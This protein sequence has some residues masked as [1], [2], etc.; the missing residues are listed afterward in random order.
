LSRDQKF[1]DMYSLVIGVLVVVALPGSE[2]GAERAAVKNADPSSK[3]SVVPVFSST[4]VSDWFWTGTLKATKSPTMTVLGVGGPVATTLG[5]WANSTCAKPLAVPVPGGEDITTVAVPT[6]VL[7]RKSKKMVPSACTLLCTP[8][9]PLASAVALPILGKL[10][11]LYGHRRVF[12]LGSSAATLLSFLTAAAWDAYSLI[13]LRVAASVIGAASGPSSMALIFDAYTPEERT[14]A[15]G[16]WSM[17]GAGA[18]ALG[19]IAGGPMVQYMGWRMLFIVQGVFSVLALVFA[20]FVLVET[21]R[22]KVR[23]DVAG[24]FLLAVS[25]GCLMFALGQAGELGLRSPWIWGAIV[26]GEASGR[27]DAAR[28]L[29]A[30]ALVVVGVALL[31][32]GG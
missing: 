8:G 12:L 16:W 24:S 5:I 30:S 6:S 4:R 32:L 2:V 27:R 19:L 3:A 1:F 28:R 9:N 10:G 18:P 22:L 31:V 14:R 29:V 26:L 17:M 23:F 7:E 20:W 25:A 11:D 13:G 15:M 21:A